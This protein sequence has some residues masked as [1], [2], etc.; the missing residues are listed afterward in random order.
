MEYAVMCGGQLIDSNISGYAIVRGGILRDSSISDYAR[1]SGGILN[2]ARVGHCT[3]VTAGVFDNIVVEEYRTGRSIRDNFRANEIS[4]HISNGVGASVITYNPAEFAGNQAFLSIQASKAHSVNEDILRMDSTAE[5]PICL[6]PVDLKTE[7]T[8]L[9]CKH[10][11]HSQCIRQWLAKY[12]TCP[13]CRRDLKNM[14][15]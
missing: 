8:R 10:W 3:S 11:F 1:V 4:M 9:L 13:I 14:D 2:H 12:N 7:I 15:K 5:C 6:E